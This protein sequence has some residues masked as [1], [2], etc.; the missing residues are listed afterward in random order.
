MAEVLAEYPDFVV[1]DDG[2]AY[3]AQACGAPNDDGLWEAWIEFTAVD[4]TMTIRS[5]RETTQPNRADTV[6]W[7][8]GLTTVYLEGALARALSPPVVR[9]PVSPASPNFDGPAPHVVIGRAPAHQRAVLDPFSVYEKSET[10]LRRELGAFSAWHL[11]NIITAYGLSDQSEDALNRLP[12]SSLVEIIMSG[13]REKSP[14][15]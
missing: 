6:Y 10:L 1:G 4:G 3:H 5:P 15:R 7:A 12:E 11:V 9:K 13:V 14:T 8:G 2:E